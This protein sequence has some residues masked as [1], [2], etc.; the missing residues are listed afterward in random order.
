[1]P[2][3]ESELVVLES[4]AVLAQ[5]LSGWPDHGSRRSARPRITPAPEPR[6]ATQPLSAKPGAHPQ[7]RLRVVPRT[8]EYRPRSCSCGA[9]DRCRDNARWNRIFEEK[10]A[11]PSYYSGI[12]IRHNSSLAS[13]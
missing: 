13:F 3:I 9:C 5:L 6:I 12:S 2:V 1:M 7:P 10:F 11:D 4:P 8:R